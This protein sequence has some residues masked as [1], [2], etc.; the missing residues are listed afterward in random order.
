MKKATNVQT[1]SQTKYIAAIMITEDIQ[2][3]LQSKFNCRLIFLI[4]ITNLRR[5][6]LAMIKNW[7]LKVTW[8]IVSSKVTKNHLQIEEIK[9]TVS[10][11]Y[12]YQKISNLRVVV[13]WGK[14]VWGSNLQGNCKIKKLSLQVHK[15]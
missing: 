9:K 15:S 8:K 11:P 3:M 4:D 14:R 13:H 6:F 5:Y 7:V 2:N 10:Q 1:I 12:I